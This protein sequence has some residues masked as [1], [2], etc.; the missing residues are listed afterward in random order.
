VLFSKKKSKKKKG[1]LKKHGISVRM[2][3]TWGLHG[4][5]G[6]TRAEHQR[7]KVY[8]MQLVL[9]ILFGASFKKK[10]KKKSRERKLFSDVKAQ[11]KRTILKPD[12]KAEKKR[13]GKFSEKALVS[14]SYRLIPKR[15]PRQR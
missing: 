5:F 15:G 4:S 12:T 13:A 3:F 11:S 7:Q 14:D 2:R 9:T 8:K 1:F 6:P 10:K